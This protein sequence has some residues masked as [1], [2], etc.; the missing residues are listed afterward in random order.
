MSTTPTQS[1]R[2]LAN[3][4]VRKAHKS[5][6]RETLFAY[7]AELATIDSLA[8]ANVAEAA[9]M[10]AAALTAYERKQPGATARNQEIQQARDGVQCECGH[11]NVRHGYPESAPDGSIST[12]YYDR[13]PDGSFIGM[14]AC[15]MD[16]DGRNY[17]EGWIREYC[18]CPGFKDANKEQTA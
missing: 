9:D 10:A 6:T 7:G 15:G 12:A 14:G 8:L 3:L 1:T 2:D 13:W 17:E 18:R 11:P 5:A 16:H 4:L